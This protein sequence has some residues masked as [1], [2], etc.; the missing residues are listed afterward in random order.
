MRDTSSVR[1]EQQLDVRRM[2]RGIVRSVVNANRLS[3]TLAEGSDPVTVP[4]VGSS[5]AYAVNDVVLVARDGTGPVVLGRVGTAPAD[6]T[7]SAP[8]PVPPPSAG[9]TRTVVVLPSSTGS[10]RSD[11]GWRGDEVRQGNYGYG[12]Y[13]G[14]AYY[15]RALSGLGADLTKPRSAVLRYARETGG[16]FAAQS[17]TVYTLNGS[18][19]PAGAP[20]RRALSAAA[21]GV[22]V[23]RS[24]SWALPANMLDELL[25]GAAGGLGIYV[26]TS[27]PYIVLSGKSGNSASMSL[28]VTYST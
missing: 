21:T 12:L 24:A 23:N 11:T 6:P 27:S 20:S 1:S 3:V 16:V 2:Q 5:I 9:V 10:W 22:A 4:A 8:P 26:P 7:P 15:G 28:A 14:A 13:H 17:P 25:S 19:R 18:T